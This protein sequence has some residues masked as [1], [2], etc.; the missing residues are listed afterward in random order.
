MKNPKLP[1]MSIDEKFLYKDR[2]SLGKYCYGDPVLHFYNGPICRLDIGSFVAFAPDVHI[3]VGGEHFT[4]Y[5]STYPFSDVFGDGGEIECVKTKG[6]V[7]IGSDVWIGTGATI[8]S[9]VTI[10]HGAVIGAKTVVSKDVEPYTVVVGSPM[11]R[12]RR[13][14]PYYSQINKLLEIKWWE[15]PDEEIQKVIP[16]LMS[17]NVDKFIEEVEGVRV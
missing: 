14:F 12:I 6:D 11:R 10:G 2:C 13:R 9:G 5:V 15:W 4:E 1:I 16:L 17:E 3:H 7:K 8:L